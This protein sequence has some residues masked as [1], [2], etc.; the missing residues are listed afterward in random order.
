MAN[1]LKP[2][3]YLAL[4]LELQPVQDN[5]SS[6]CTYCQEKLAFFVSDELA[7]FAVDDIYADIA[8]HLDLCESCL[9]EYRDLSELA[10]KALFDLG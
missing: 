3:Q 5:A 10:A 6:D 7:G 4:Q 8:A 9:Q 1:S 2:L